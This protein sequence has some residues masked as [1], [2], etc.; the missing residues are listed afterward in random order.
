MEERRMACRLVLVLPSVLVTAALSAS[1]ASVAEITSTWNAAGGFW[2][3][4]AN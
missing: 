1:K 4:A 2:S 3:A